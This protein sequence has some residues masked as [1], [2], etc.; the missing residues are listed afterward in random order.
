MK[1]KME[2]IE[3]L[4][5]LPSAIELIELDVLT[6]SKKMQ[7]IADQIIDQEVSIKS[8]INSA[9]DENGKKVYSND[10]ARH[11]A[12]VEEVKQNPTLIELYQR[13]D[14]LDTSIKQS[15]I[16][17]EKMQNQQ[18]NIRSVIDHI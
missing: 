5:D 17:L 2:L 15:R 10:Q 6:K 1:S 12:F 11:A 3:E 8:D 18:R 7:E 4:M 16:A 14:L 9:I 13:R